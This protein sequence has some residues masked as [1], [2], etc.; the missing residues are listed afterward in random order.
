MRA[1][2]ALLLACWLPLTS[3][4][5]VRDDLVTRYYEVPVRPGESL[6]QQVRAASPIR[7][8]GAVYYGD[9][10]WNAHW[11]FRWNSDASGRCRLTSVQVSLRAEILLPQLRGADGRQAAAF[12]RFI[13]A[14]RRHEMGHYEHGRQAAAEIERDLL[15]LPPAASCAALEAQAN[16][17]A[18]RS[19]ARY[20]AMDVQYD[21]ETGHGRTQGARLE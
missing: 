2:H 17:G 15:A 18:H 1:S 3:A 11:N 8:D 4:A 6:N 12:E 16:Q 7:D 13:T 19:V 5:Q 21:R 14:L 9:T 20:A 10:H